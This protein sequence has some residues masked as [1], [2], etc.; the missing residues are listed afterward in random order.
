M[1]KLI[2]HKSAVFAIDSGVKAQEILSAGGDGWVVKWNIDQPDIGNVIAK[3]DTNIFSLLHLKEHQLL[4]IGNRNGGVHWV[5][6]KKPENTKNIL[7]HSKGVFDIRLF[8]DYV[9]SIG[10][11]G[12]LTKWSIQ[13][14]R[15]IESIKL[16]TASLRSMDYCFLKKELAVG[17]SDKHIYFLDI[18]TFEF[19]RK[20]E[21]AHLNS[22]FAVK[23]SPDMKYLLSG[24][25]DAQL[26]IWNMENDQEIP[27][28]YAAHMY[29]INSIA[30]HHKGNIF[31][32]ASRD[33]TIKI[34]DAQNFDLLKVIESG[35]AEGH[36][37][38][39][40]KLF[41]SDYNNYLI[42]A[43]DDRSLMIWDIEVVEG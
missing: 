20:I 9:F 43:S 18:D 7:H 29:T 16:S 42:S 22:V 15:A 17:A 30:F 14:R 24:G 36:R 34:W 35:K 13:E 28:K 32:T 38:S 2:G 33:R 37:A 4:V 39:V 31:A 40:N 23:Y 26:R 11:G 12:K 5:D 41:W 19:K 21:N 25:R 27:M 1:A 6:L 8:G 3:I 10:G